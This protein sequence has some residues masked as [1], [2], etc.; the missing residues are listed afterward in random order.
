[1]F[2]SARR[3]K[4]NPMAEVTI[5]SAWDSFERNVVP[6]SAGPGQRR[7]MFLAFM[8]GATVITMAI[9]AASGM[10]GDAGVAMLDRLCDE[11]DAFH[12]VMSD[13]RDAR[14]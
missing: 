11:V 4:G 9:E 7:D 1:M 8:G 6:K 14:K 3:S 5:L 2:P 12:D 10:P 13:R